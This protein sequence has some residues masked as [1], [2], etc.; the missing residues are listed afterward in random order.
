MVVPKGAVLS[1]PEEC[2]QELVSTSFSTPLNNY[3]QDFAQVCNTLHTLFSIHSLIPKSFYPIADCDS[4]LQLQLWT[5]VNIMKYITWI[6]EAPWRVVLLLRIRDRNSI[7]SSK[8]YLRVSKLETLFL[9]PKSN[10]DW[11][12][13]QNCQL[14]SDQYCKLFLNWQEKMRKKKK[15]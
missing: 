1:V 5:L 11:V 9:I 3:Q 8:N 12:S 13:I 10:E 4:R 15:K 2:S 7:V 14:S 6:K